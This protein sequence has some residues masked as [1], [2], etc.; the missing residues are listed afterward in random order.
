T[1]YIHVEITNEYECVRH[2]SVLITVMPQFSADFSF[3]KH[4]SC[5]ETP[6]ILF[7]NL[8]EGAEAFSWELGDGTLLDET[9]PTHNYHQNDTFTVRL[10]AMLDVCE[11]SKELPVT[12]IKT[13]IPNVITPNG[14]GKNDTFQ[15][16]TAEP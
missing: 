11:K 1:T 5:T 13:V 12:S 4:N 3:A 14:D 10:R 8:S 6:N 2:D 7:T 9:S 16:I 15:V